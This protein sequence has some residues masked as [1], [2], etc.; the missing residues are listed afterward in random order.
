MEGPMRGAF[1]VAARL[2]ERAAALS[3]AIAGDHASVAPPSRPSSA[4]AP[5]RSAVTYQRPSSARS[6]RHPEPPPAYSVNS[7]LSRNSSSD[8]VQKTL[9]RLQDDGDRLIGRISRSDSPQHSPT[10]PEDEVRSEV[11]AAEDEAGI[12]CRMHGVIHGSRPPSAPLIGRQLWQL[13]DDLEATSSAAQHVLGGHGQECPWEPLAERFLQER[14]STRRDCEALRQLLLELRSMNTEVQDIT[15]QQLTGRG[16]DALVVTLR[17]EMRGGI[18]A[19]SEVCSSRANFTMPEELSA[20]RTD[21]AS[22]QATLGNLA[23]NINDGRKE[24]S[25]TAIGLRGL[26][27][28]TEA[29]VAKGLAELREALAGM[30]TDFSSG[31]RLWDD[32]HSASEVRTA[33]KEATTEGGL[34]QIAVQLESLQKV[35]TNQSQDLAVLASNLARLTSKQ[36]DMTAEVKSSVQEAIGH[37]D[38]QGDTVKRVATAVSHLVEQGD[39]IEFKFP[40]GVKQ[41]LEETQDLKQKI[42]DGHHEHRSNLAEVRRE[43]AKKVHLDELLKKLE[44]HNNTIS[45]SIETFLSSIAA[46]ASPKS[47]GRNS[48]SSVDRFALTPKQVLVELKRIEAKGNLSINLNN[49]DVEVHNIPFVPKKPPNTPTADFVSMENAERVLADIAE[50]DTL[51]QVP[52]RIEGH[53]RYVKSGTSEYWQDLA[54][55]RARKIGSVLQK[56][57][58]PEEQM[59]CVGLPGHQGMNKAGVMVKFDIFPELD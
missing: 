26:H 27:D 37:V 18:R 36:E 30:R 42:V 40:A 4:R 39:R 50:I 45:Q 35:V 43:V 44:A 29:S 46:P 48:N 31:M 16:L 1:S 11:G 10:K 6:S 24:S 51:F 7:A 3:G 21:I 12:Q 59:T 2:E 9:S 57:G 5:S 41:V 38:K 55:N 54:D 15:M 56:M 32:Q 52:L 19:L 17:E 58:I 34:Q 8:F 49:G 14:E 53:T 28:A 47:P 22:I 25:E 20:L 33:L 23:K 13:Q